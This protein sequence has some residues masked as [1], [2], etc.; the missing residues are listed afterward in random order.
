MNRVKSYK[1]TAE[2]PAS[3]MYAVT[4]DDVAEIGAI[5][6]KA[7]RVGGGG[8]LVGRGLDGVDVTLLNVQDGEIVPVQFQYIR[9]TG[10]TCTGIVALY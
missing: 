2:S 10:T 4:P 3:G 1:E 5:V 9:A 7:I 6:P 8:T